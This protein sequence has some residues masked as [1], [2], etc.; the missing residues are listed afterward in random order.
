MKKMGPLEKILEMLPGGAALG[1]GKLN[2]E[3]M[4]TFSKRAEAIIQSMTV[5]ERRHPEILNGSRRLRIARGSGT[6]PQDVNDLIRQFK[7]AK[8]MAKKIG[9]MQKKLQRKR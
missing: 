8:L 3:E 4:N 6:Q 2:T 7:Q 1:A 5:R 9:M